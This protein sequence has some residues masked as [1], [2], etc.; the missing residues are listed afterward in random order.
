MY[1]FE[2]FFQDFNQDEDEMLKQALQASI[3]QA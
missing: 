3:E 1:F 2:F